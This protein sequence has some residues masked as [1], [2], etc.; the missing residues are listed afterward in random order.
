MTIQIV[1]SPTITLLV[2]KRVFQPFLLLSVCLFAY[3]CT[4]EEPRA[5]TAER[6]EITGT[7]MKT[8]PVI[9]SHQY[10]EFHIDTTA[11]RSSSIDLN[12][13]VDELVTVRGYQIEGYPLSGG[14]VY[15]E[16][17]EIAPVG[18]SPGGGD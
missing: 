7:L 2:M 1:N 11:L 18:L 14:P 15:V 10:G 16:V 5:S 4:K 6:V 9:T 8:A 17:E 12:A 3:A 13:F